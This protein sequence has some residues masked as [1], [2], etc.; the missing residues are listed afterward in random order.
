MGVTL[1][2]SVT[3]P[4]PARSPKRHR[5]L[6]GGVLALLAVLILLERA[7]TY[8]E[9]LERDI[10]GYAVIAHEMRGG[11]KLYSD[12]WERKPPLVY[13]AFE[14]AEK[15]AGYGPREIYLV[16][17]AAALATMLG[18]YAAGAAESPLAGL[19]AAGL[20][21][22]LSG[23]LLLEANQ[24][25]AEVLVNAALTAAFALLMRWPESRRA[26]RVAAV[27]LGI[28]FAAAT[29]TKHHVAIACL[30][31]T[32]GHLLVRHGIPSPGRLRR[33]AA[34]SAIAL[35][36][37]GMAWAAV[38]GYFAASG[39]ASQL[40]DI[41]FHQN[42]NYAAGNASGG[43]GAA[44]IIAANLAQ[45]FRFKNIFPP[46]M[47]W[48]VVP[49]MLVLLAAVLAGIGKGRWRP[50]RR[51]CV[52]LAW[53][54]GIWAVIAVPGQFF[55]HY[56]QLWLPLWCVAGGWAT[57]A[58]VRPA[59]AL[60]SALRT[61]AVITAFALLLYRQGSQYR[62]PGA[63]W[64][65]RKNVG[66]FEEDQK[67]GEALRTFLLPN[68]TFWNLGQEN[69]LYFA[70]RRS[71]PSGLLYMDP[72]LTGDESAAYQQRLM[73]DLNRTRPPLVVVSLA[74]GPMYKARLAQA[75]CPVESWLRGNYLVTSFN[76]G[77]PDFLLLVRRGTDL[78]RRLV[79][80]GVWLTPLEKVVP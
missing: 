48:V 24:P 22:M 2:P 65:I 49:V 31:L 43:G 23:D 71:P 18:M 39:R 41:L 51:W 16:N 72:W 14:L 53:S 60:P 6:V 3:E 28:C 64:V 30:A 26:G 46:W 25:N 55:P 29:L 35:G 70:A 4:A 8:A 34:E 38:F 19:A 44:G 20:W 80:Q 58:L 33:R 54:A 40:L 27:A 12:L 47:H 7:R 10:T 36:V 77:C 45:S 67:L 74:W 42:L 32:L 75:S 62:T 52:W 68:E 37:M 56:Y 59:A 63:Q 76:G 11:R 21:V 17:V 69:T 9:P 50:G 61:A 66:H 57:A 79:R 78:E 73:R 13:A 1:P 5:W 15:L